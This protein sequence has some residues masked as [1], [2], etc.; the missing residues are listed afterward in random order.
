MI[1]HHPPHRRR[2][3]LKILLTG[4]LIDT[5]PHDLR[6]GHA[7]VGHFISVDARDGAD[8]EG[9]GCEGISRDGM[10][11]VG[12]GVRGYPQDVRYL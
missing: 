3:D 1:P 11:E 6:T 4:T 9:T 10:T 2:N 8:G 7:D 12:E 5:L